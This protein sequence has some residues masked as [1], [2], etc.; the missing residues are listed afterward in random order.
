[1]VPKMARSKEFDR[2]EALRRA[3]PV[4]WE[5]GFAGTSTDDLVAAMGIGKQ[6]LYDTFGDKRRLF[7]EA[8]RTYC[9]ESVAALVKK[10]SAGASR[11]AAIEAVLVEL[12]N[13]RPSRRAM[14]CLGVNSICELGDDEDVRAVTAMAAGFQETALTSLIEEAKR[15]RE[16]SDSVDPRAAARFLAAILSGMRVQAKGGASV[17]A[18]RDVAAFAVQGLRR[19]A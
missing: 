9:T 8:L 10:V 2:D 6:S 3:I 4:F 5:R 19:P 1:M 12:A 13:E 16:V 15:R 18:L 11:L 14:G 17:E 7:L